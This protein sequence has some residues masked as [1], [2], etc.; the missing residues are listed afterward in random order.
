MRVGEVWQAVESHFGV[1]QIKLAAYA[2]DD[3]WYVELLETDDWELASWLYIADCFY[4]D[5]NV[6]EE[7]WD[8]E[9]IFKH[10]FKVSG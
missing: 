6:A 3:C 7:P 1:V 2:G 8:A 4:D 10:F 9:H 5:D